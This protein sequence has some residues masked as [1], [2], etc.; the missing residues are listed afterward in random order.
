[1]SLTLNF[2]LF[3]P[4]VL[5]SFK[6]IKSYYL[7]WHRF[8]LDIFSVFPFEI[9]ASFAPLSR[10]GQHHLWIYFR[11]NRTIYYL[12]F[13]PRQFS[14]WEYSL[15]VKI[16]RIRIIKFVI[17]IYTFTHMCSCFFY[18]WSCGYIMQT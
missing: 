9:I 7:V 16:V 14:K 18:W 3:L 6:D 1:M 8:W 15:D 13:I 4:G 11:L 12:R 17:Y 2:L 10:L 5:T